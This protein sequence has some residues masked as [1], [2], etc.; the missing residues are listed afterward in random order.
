[1]NDK[2]DRSTVPPD[3]VRRIRGI[4]RERK[5][6]PTDAELAAQTGLSVRMVRAIG[7]GQRYGNVPD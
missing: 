7:S 4:F 2:P 1:M 6:L 3:T 5:A